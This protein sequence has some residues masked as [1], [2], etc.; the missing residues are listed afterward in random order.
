MAERAGSSAWDGVRFVVIEAAPFIMI[1]G[2]L[3]A[4]VAWPMVLGTIV[5]WLALAGI[6][7]AGVVWVR[8][9]YRIGR[10]RGR[11]HRGG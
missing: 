10:R 5:F 1:F 11:Q 4:F 6:G 2:L 8:N 7:T 9:T 3:A